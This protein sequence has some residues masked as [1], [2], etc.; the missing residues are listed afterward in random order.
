MLLA[1][2]SSQTLPSGWGWSLIF[3][4]YS[5]W[6]GLGAGPLGVC[7]E[8]LCSFIK[9]KKKSFIKKPQ[10][11]GSWAGCG[12]TAKGCEISFGGDENILKLNR[13]AG[14]TAHWIY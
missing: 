2:A 4:T 12:G 8:F 5:S 6:P 11:A 13:N 9:K 14:F 1:E 3:Q 7:T 10:M